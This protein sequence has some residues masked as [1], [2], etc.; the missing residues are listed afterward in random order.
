MRV[1]LLVRDPLPDS[2]GAYTFVSEVFNALIKYDSSSEHTFLI[3]SLNQTTFDNYESKSHIKFIPIPYAWLGRFALRLLSNKHEK[4]RKKT[5]LTSGI[6]V[7]N[8]F[9]RLVLNRFIY[10]IFE[11]EIIKLLKYHKADICWYLE[12]FCLTMDLPYIFTL[13]DLEHRSKP[14]FPEVS[15]SGEWEIRERFYSTRLRRA[16]FVITGTHIGKKEIEKYYHIPSSRIRVLPFPTPRFSL[17]EIDTKEQNIN[18]KYNL[19]D[20]YLFYPAQFWPHKNHANLILAIDLLNKQ[21]HIKMPLVLVGTD[22]GNKKFIRNMVD[23][24]VL[25]EQIYFL[26]FVP[27]EDL[28]ALYRNAFAL[29]Y[30]T[31][32][33][34]DNL[35]PLE[36]F[37]LGCPVIASEISGASEQLDNVVIFVDPTKPNQIA[38]A[39]KTLY[40]DESLRQILIERGYEKSAK[41]TGYNYIN[42]IFDILDEFEEIRR[43]WD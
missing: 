19:P 28:I 21:Y 7:R 13:W 14:F 23:K 6:K 33:G 17:Q 31:F 36:A 25:S 12:P 24:L 11:R 29:S 9:K 15:C 35:P 39:V 38:K 20:K 42:G 27:L 43:C 3:L 32:F 37:S 34:P 5:N 4:K 30:V 1:A 26:G 41:W 18:Q 8:V 10:S 40:E 16:T 22:K 2:G